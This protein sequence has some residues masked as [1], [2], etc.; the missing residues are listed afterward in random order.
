MQRLGDRLVYS[1]Q[2]VIGFT[3]CAHLT[4]LERSA[5]EGQIQRQRVDDPQL[6]AIRRR[7]AEHERRVLEAYEARGLSLIRVERGG[8]TE[9][10]V[11]HAADQ[12]LEAMRQ[13]AD[14]IYQAALFDG[15]R[16]GYAD[17]LERTATSDGGARL[18][19]PVD[20]KLARAASADAILQL[21]HYA[22]L[23]ESVQGSAP[24]RLHLILGDG[25]R[26]SFRH[27]DFAAYY[28][29]VRQ[30]LE[31]TLASA[32]P[33]PYPDPVAHC[34]V[35]E[36]AP[37]CEARRR[38]DDHLS[39]VAGMRS[40]QARRLNQAGIATL[41]ELAGAP[42]ERVPG[43]GAESF[44]RLKAQARLQQRGR[45]SGS[46]HYEV[47]APRSVA[48]GLALLPAPSPGDLFF[49]MEGDPLVENGGLE[50]LFGVSWV[51]EG[52][53]CYQAFWAH[54][55]QEEKQAFEALVDLISERLRRYPDLHV[56]HYAP[57]E[58]A[59]LKRLMGAHATR[60]AEVDAL[61]RGRVLVD[62]YRVV[63]QGI[64]VSQESYSLKKL[65][66]LYMP[67]RQGQVK[68][69]GSSIV[70]YE[71]W[72][73]SGE[74]RIL[75]EIEEYNRVDCESTRL[76]RDWLEARRAELDRGGEPLP[77]PVAGGATD[78]TAADG[79][80]TS[81][82]PVQ[83]LADGLRGLAGAGDAA[84]ADHDAARMLLSHLLEW[85]RREQKP[86]W[87]DHFRL[88]EA[89][90]D[91][92][93]EDGASLGGLAFERE[94]GR[95]KQSAV[96]A[97]RFDPDQ[98]HKIEV[99][100]SP[101]DPA[102]GGGVGSVEHLDGARGE[103]H[104]KRG[105]RS[106]AEHPR[107]LIPP[108]P[109]G[110]AVLREAVQRAAR[111]ALERDLDDD[112][113][114]RAAFDLLRRRRPRLVGDGV[115]SQAEPLQR[116]DEDALAAARR[117]VLELDGSYLAVQG[118][119][120]SGKTFTG[121]RMIVDLVAQ[122]RRV[123][124]T[125]PSHRAIGNLL[126][127]ACEYADEA[128]VDLAAAQ[129]ADG[130]ALVNHARVTSVPSNGVRGSLDDGSCNVVA[131]TAWALAREDLVGQLDTLFV[132]E[133]GQ[134]SLANAVAVAGAAKNLVLLGDPQQ[135]AQPSKGT[136]PP[137]AEKSALEH[138][139]GEAAT[140]PPKLGLLL[141][142]S[143][144]MHPELC[145]FISEVAYDDRLRAAEHCAGQSLELPEAFRGA[146]PIHLAVIHGDNR[147]RALEEVDAIAPL[148]ES[149]RAGEWTDPQGQA[150]PIGAHD[151]LV[152]APYNAQ[153]NLLAQRLP[154][155]SR[156]GTVDRFQGQEAAVAIYSLTASSGEE[157]SRGLEF[158]L[159]LNRLNV[160]ISRARVRAILV[161]S[162]ELLRARCASI[163]DMR[164]LN[165]LCRFVEL[166]S[167]SGLDR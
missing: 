137:G 70:A 151:V 59:A 166:A 92:L 161:C 150:R 88:R 35:C 110:D 146:G 14:V 107:A 10:E 72:I 93:L 152:V 26:E 142:R 5:A 98:E 48:P 105:L 31:D 91:E 65:E 103:I 22:S 16:L 36:W 50:Y 134:F 111:A 29:S 86:D 19:E 46:V 85:H 87:W 82:H 66:P 73:Q 136:H 122:G 40:D 147:I 121:A 159:S 149:L 155:G 17:F 135:L 112:A 165:A 76:L 132:D 162:P 94:V 33:P 54:S 20:T 101:L 39:L 58:E 47:I 67:P 55:R 109:I 156:V 18:Y 56:Y 63:R 13:G 32:A 143:W 38:A 78:E 21:C 120:G 74:Q 60:E 114:Y 41:A 57:Y 12:T 11:Q 160:A 106:Q 52:R 68:D 115:C 8:S 133:A 64:R 84:S 25:R 75:D 53:P 45:E 154:P 69:A 116:A 42:R 34:A 127:A 23:L 2:D 138:V 15:R 4:W 37:R 102:T 167:G 96:Y 61:L 157:V 1:A 104:L 131:G 3:A 7:G 27:R 123:G 90:D 49:D 153:V 118:P 113:P 97:Y 148:V 100:S 126:A 164:Q 95:V 77:R 89:S 79:Q 80:P 130:D 30:R 128:G 44:A 83:E 108:K 43:V 163:K 99:G 71:R 145:R 141:D 62:L 140:I 124:I 144:R 117:L 81:E 119:P 51:E 24:E 6:A 28:R 158:L 129:R 139:I 125:G 9:A